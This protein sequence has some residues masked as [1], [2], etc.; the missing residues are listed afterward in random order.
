MKKIIQINTKSKKYDVVMD[1]KHIVDLINNEKEANKKNYIIIDSKIS[2]LLKGLK[3]D[4]LTHIIK[5]KGSEK[6]KSFEHYSSLILK[7]LKLKIDRE[8]KLI[9]IGGGTIGDLSGFVASTTLRGIKFVLIPTTLLSQVDSSIGG[10]NGI[11]TIYGKNLVG[12]FFQPDKVIICLRFLETLP[13][14]EMK[15]GYAE[16]LKHALIYDKIFYNWLL[17]NYESIFEKKESHLLKAISRSIRIKYNFIKNDEK[18]NL[19][20][21][22]SRAMLNFG[23]TFG[24]ALETM[25][26]YNNQLNHG[27]AIAIGMVCATKISNKLK[28]INNKDYLSLINHLKNVGLPSHNEKIFSNTFYNTILSDKKNTDGKINLILLKKIGNAYYK[29]GLKL[30]EIK[31]LLK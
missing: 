13:D 1:N 26:K 12:T 31:R 19:I 17:K 9:A 20:N 27:E 22:S 3:K 15:S 10:K 2:N 14:R 5:I 30:G 18:E 25:N 16:I 24:H 8:S 21:S 11:N 29:R 23:H 6:V 28:F 7:L 4:K